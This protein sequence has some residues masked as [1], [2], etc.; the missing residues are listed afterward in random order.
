MIKF[1]ERLTFIIEHNKINQTEMAK[2]LK[3]AKST[4]S[5]YKTGA[6]VPSLKVFYKICEYLD[7]SADYLLGLSDN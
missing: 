3:L 6:A 2:T 4:I 1:P 5:N 7:E